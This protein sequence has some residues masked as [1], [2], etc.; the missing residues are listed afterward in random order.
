M[1]VSDVIVDAAMEAAMKVVEETM[2]F[3]QR[4][5]QLRAGGMEAALVH[6]YERPVIEAAVLAAF[7]KA[8]EMA[9]GTGDR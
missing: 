2:G 9:H 7:Q 4:A 1:K 8:V 3:T 6:Q 5:N